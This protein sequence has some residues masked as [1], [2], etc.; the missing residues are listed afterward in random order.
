MTNV[1]VFPY[2][3]TVGAAQALYLGQTPISPR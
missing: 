3:L 1:Q 2:A